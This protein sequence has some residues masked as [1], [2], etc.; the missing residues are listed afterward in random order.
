MRRGEGLLARFDGARPGQH[1][2]RLTAPDRDVA[3]TND[4]IRGMHLA[5]AQLER[6]AD[7]DDLG[8]PRKR[9]ELVRVLAG[10]DAERADGG[11]LGAG[12]RDG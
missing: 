1:R 9:L 11:P 8:D 6:P 3:H 4:R 12:Q 7:Q 10:G 2:E 5:R